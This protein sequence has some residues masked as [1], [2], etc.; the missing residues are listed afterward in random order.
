MVFRDRQFYLHLPAVIMPPFWA[1]SLF[2]YQFSIGNQL[3]WSPTLIASAFLALA[4]SRIA[5]S[6][7]IG[8]LVDHLGAKTL[9]PYHLLPFA[10]GLFIAFLNP[11]TWSAF[12]YMFL[13]GVT[14]GMG[15][16]I[17]A[18][19]WVDMYGK[20]C[21]GSVKSL[22]SSIMIV[23]SSLSPFMLGYLLDSHVSVFQILLAAVISMSIATVLAFLAFRKEPAN[24]VQR[25]SSASAIHNNGIFK[26]AVTRRPELWNAPDPAA[27]VLC[28]RDEIL[29]LYIVEKQDSGREPEVHRTPYNKAG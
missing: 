19:L 29:P 6:L 4:L 7:A 22:F 14:L 23:C 10:G 18:S 17:T 26:P 20:K 9:F 5:S 15:G 27:P 28:F 11:G 13:I 24:K 21:V 3:G 8:P 16:N 12:A 2:L 25:Q 1:T